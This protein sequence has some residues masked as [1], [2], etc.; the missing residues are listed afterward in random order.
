MI[1]LNVD[2]FLM[3]SIS[4]GI[5]IFFVKLP[6]NY[7]PKIVK[8]QI[9]LILGKDFDGI[10]SLSIW[11]CSFHGL[12]HNMLQGQHCFPQKFKQCWVYV[13]PQQVHDSILVQNHTNHLLCVMQSYTWGMW[14]TKYI[15]SHR[16]HWPWTLMH[17]HHDD[18]ISCLS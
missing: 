12:M 18:A 4:W 6:K 14:L 2:K 9:V 5:H 13:K 8:H 11:G 3:R 10:K 15:S 1:S 7:E 16:L 17:N